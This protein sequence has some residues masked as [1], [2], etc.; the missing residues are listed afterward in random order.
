MSDLSDDI[1]YG[2][3]SALAG[4]IRGKSISPVDV[5]EAHLGRIEEVN[6]GLNALVTMADGALDEARGAE[7][8]IMRGES[9]GPLHG[10]P[11][12]IK[13]CIDTAGIRTTR[14]SLL[15]KDRTP[16]QDAT[17]VTRLKEAGGILL[18]K[19]NM[20]EFALWWET[21]NRVFGRTENPWLNGRTPGGSSGGEAAA[22]A[23]GLSP[24]GVGSDV[25]GSI[26]QPA[27][28]CGIVGLKPTH[29]RIPLTGHWPDTLLRF[30]HVGPMA[31]TVDDVALALTILSG[32]DG[33]DPAAPPVPVP[34]LADFDGPAGALRVGWCADGPFAPVEAG[35]RETVARAATALEEL[36]CRVEQVSLRFMEDLDPQ[37]ISATIYAAEGGYYLEPII[38]GRHDE[39]A[40]S[41]RRRLDQPG[42]SLTEYLDARARCDRL[43]VEFTR[44]FLDHEVLLCPTGPVTARPHDSYELVIAEEK[45]PGRNA[46]RCT[47]PFDL[48][49]SPAISIPFGWSHEG[50]PIGVQLVCRHFDE[51]TLLRTA[52]ALEGLT[53]AG[54]R[55]PPV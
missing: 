30:M 46:L 9:W 33:V 17:V 5:V 47:I 36:G 31:R 12:T 52:R 39:L 2:D 6:P 42:P 55:R 51:P 29:G 28:Y 32:P 1:Y 16:D 18:G 50:L 11:F 19:T 34:E 27:N 40:E 38:A 54:P 49:G 10:V 25:G 14:G 37:E 22:I 35:V 3:A 7:A 4:L 20:P 21:G 43:R 8:A 48:T 23:A 44:F 53:D 45:V 13:D 24:L 41:M 26:R 15:F